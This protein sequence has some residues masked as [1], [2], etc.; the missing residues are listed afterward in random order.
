MNETKI[1]L[2]T[3]TEV[4]LTGFSG[5]WTSA[6]V[7]N[8]ERWEI[9]AI[10]GTAT[11][12]ADPLLYAVVPTVNDWQAPAWYI[13]HSTFVKHYERSASPSLIHIS[14]EPF[15]FI[16]P[17]LDF[18]LTSFTGATFTITDR[19]NG[20]Q[21]EIGTDDTTALRLYI[22]A[23]MFR[24]AYVSGDLIGYGGSTSPMSA[25]GA[26][27]KAVLD[28]CGFGVWTV[29]TTTEP[30]VWH[31]SHDNSGGKT[32][33]IE[34][35]GGNTQQLQ[36]TIGF[37]V[38][39][40][41]IYTN[42]LTSGTSYV[43]RISVSSFSG[44]GNLKIYLGGAL[45]GTINCATATPGTF[46]YTGLAND[47]EFRLVCDSTA[48]VVIDGVYVATIPQSYW[49]DTY[50]TVP[51][52]LT[53]QIADI[54][55]ADKRHSDFSKTIVLPGTKNNNQ[56][57]KH[58]SGLTVEN[59]F[60]LNKK[61]D[62][63]VYADGIPI[64]D[65]FLQL[66]RANVDKRT[67]TIEYEVVI[68]GYNVDIFERLGDKLLTDLDLTDLFHIRDE[69]TIIDSWTGN[70][71][72]PGYV[73]PLIDWG[74]DYNY[75][76]I[77]TLGGSIPV[78]DLYPAVY[79]RVWVDKI[80]SENGF[81]YTSNFFDSSLFKQLIIPYDGTSGAFPTRSVTLHFSVGYTIQLSAN[82]YQDG[83]NA[84]LKFGFGKISP[85]GVFYPIA[86]ADHD[87]NVYTLV[88]SNINFTKTVNVEIGWEVVTYL[89]TS[90]VPNYS[91][92]TVW[93]GANSYFSGVYNDVD[94]NHPDGS[95]RVSL[96]SPRMVDDDGDTVLDG[97]LS[98]GNYA[99][100]YFLFPFDDES[101]GS[102]SD[103][104]NTFDLT[105]SAFI[106]DVYFGYISS[107]GVTNP[108]PGVHTVPG[109]T[110]MILV[111]NGIRQADLL[112]ALIKMFNLYIEPDRFN[113]K[114]LFIEPRD[115][116]YDDYTTVRNWTK[117][118]DVSKPIKEEFMSEL[119]DKEFLF[120]YKLDKDFYNDDYNG[121][122]K[123]VYGDYSF[124]SQNEFV[125]DTK[126]VEVV[127]AST[128]L[129]PLLNVAVPM[130]D[131]VISKIGQ[132]NSSAVWSPSTQLVPR[133][134]FYKY[135]A[136]PN[137]RHWYFV[138]TNYTTYPYAGHLNDPFSS[139]V[140]L[141]FGVCDFYYPGIHI[142]DSNLFTRYYKRQLDEIN[143]I[144]SKLVTAFFNLHP[145]DV[146][147]IQFNQLIYVDNVY[148]RLNKIQDFDIASSATTR[149][150]LQKVLDVRRD[151]ILIS[152]VDEDFS[153][154]AGWTYSGGAGWNGT[155]GAYPFSSGTGTLSQTPAV[156]LA[157]GET[158]TVSFTLTTNFTGFTCTPSL[159]GNTAGSPGTF[160]ASN[161]TITYNVN[162]VAGAGTD[163][164]FLIGNAS[165][166]IDDI[167][168]YR[169]EAPPAVIYID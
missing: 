130:N 98:P 159:G 4:A 104:F 165:G 146:L 66:V 157:P 86:N 78:F 99:L 76:A 43:T 35:N 107:Y 102:N 58:I 49:L 26:A 9:D 67:D 101:T 24:L 56:V 168:V 44:T 41:Q 164:E 106:P 153:L 115:D 75:S 82:N 124:V 118:L 3:K 37:G 100:G 53:Y 80:F 141:N 97:Y 72:N 145:K 18:A 38:F 125:K 143:N 57:F 32:D 92:G 128:P 103:A 47:N 148:Y 6:N 88:P 51:F 147:N 114:N 30:G 77:S 33:Y 74:K 52:P 65:G 48:G 59:V 27:L 93:V 113:P 116:Y 142:T 96:V 69:T 110:P 64:L 71:A 150:E 7:T 155:A 161:E 151:N 5:N 85:D 149:V 119:Q 167:R 31:L 17:T 23:G 131:F 156:A 62:C 10:T 132:V 95:F 154:N 36:G 129:V 108:Q 61:T 60:D 42:T 70:W 137:G 121:K 136:L 89:K 91:T 83:T 2:R 11:H 20:T 73:Y 134:L 19:A 63:Q 112:M 162:I 90:N 25:G 39:A 68:Y 105:G 40:D 54:R 79:A 8:V 166:S 138:S 28:T 117:K 169:Y 50:T 87:V 109:N 144:D 45:I 15:L 94:A 160:S 29:D 120:T 135:S 163:V 14:T 55:E 139:T 133:I 34:R 81:T 111:A 158:Y 22:Y 46:E 21:A 12:T 140:D 13:N 123:K 16:H 84:V 152:V 122:T 127:F 126:N 1:L